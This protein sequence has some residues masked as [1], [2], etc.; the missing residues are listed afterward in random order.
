[1]GRDDLI[2][3][4][5]QIKWNK[6]LE[7]LSLLKSFQIPRCYLPQNFGVIRHACVHH[8]SDASEK[9]YGNVSYLRLVDNNDNVQ[10]SFLLGK[11]KLAPLKTL[12]TPRLE[13]C[14]ATVSIR[15]NEILCKELDLDCQLEPSVFWTDS[16]S[17]RA[18]CI[19]DR[20]T[21]LR[22]INSEKGMFHRFVA[23]RI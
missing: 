9:S 23:N 4:V 10:C 6:L 17:T 19:L 8:F 20:Q 12:T 18:F 13:L 21:V 14:A 16:S 1:M 7:K 15:L 22:Y 11:T 5:F 2:P 3:R